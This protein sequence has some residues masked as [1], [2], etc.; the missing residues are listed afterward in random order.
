M[1]NAT[2]RTPYWH[3]NVPESQ[4]TEECPEYLLNL[5][6]KDLGIISTPDSTYRLG[7]WPEVQEIIAENRLEL[8][9]RVPS[10]LVRYLENNWN[11]RKRYGSVMNFVLGHRLHWE[12]P[13]KARGAPFQYEEDYKI[14]YND[15]PYGIDPRI[16]HLV[17]WTKF[18]LKDDPATG[19]LTDQA[20]AE[21]EGFVRETFGA[22]DPD[23]VRRALS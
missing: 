23:H 20:R 10:D 12:A 15:W 17:V 19:D 18:E 7:T 4:R 14:L 2:D 1:A 6:A 21:I 3:I 11:L 13:V 5:S 22:V 8:F 9:Q 16:V